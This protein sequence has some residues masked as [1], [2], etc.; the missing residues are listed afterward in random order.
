MHWLG[1]MQE[2]SIICS[3]FI[4]QIRP[5]EN[6]PLS[7]CELPVKEIVI[8]RETDRFPCFE[9]RWWGEWC[10]G[11]WAAS[12]WTCGLVTCTGIAFGLKSYS[13]SRR[14]AKRLEVPIDL[15]LE[16]GSVHIFG[17][18]TVRCAIIFWNENVYSS[19]VLRQ[20]GYLFVVR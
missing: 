19:K 3:F 1:N 12:W 20:A 4:L 2:L 16:Q 10:K 18:G 17:L 14:L 11:L 8:K 5:T 9:T 7:S 6:Y 15:N 13:L